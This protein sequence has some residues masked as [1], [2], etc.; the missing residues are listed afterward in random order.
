[1]YSV[2]NEPAAVNKQKKI[3]KQTELIILETE[4][5]KREQ[6]TVHAAIMKINK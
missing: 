3:K 6:S 5:N 4:T 1:M 2:T